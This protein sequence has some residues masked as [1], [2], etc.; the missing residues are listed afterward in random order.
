MKF[1]VLLPV[2]IF[3]LGCTSCNT[4]FKNNINNSIKREGYVVLSI[5][6]FKAADSA[7]SNFS[8]TFKPDSN[9]LIIKRKMYFLENRLIDIIINE[10]RSNGKFIRFDTIGYTLF[11]LSTQKF[12]TFKELALDASLIRKGSLDSPGG[13]FSNNPKFDVM[14]GIS[15]SGWYVSDTVINNDSIG[16]I[17]F[18]IENADSTE[19]EFTKMSKLWV[20]YSI[21]DFPLQI[22]YSLSKKLRNG[23]VYK[24]QQPFPD[25]KSF[26]ITS[27]TF[28]PAGLED[29]IK[30][31]FEAWKTITNN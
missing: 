3:I 10:N 14:S 8:Q 31:I 13:G 18:K 1:G 6:T 5:E 4:G 16:I 30:K 20:N 11:D 19:I 15:D 29:S 23:F 17:N 25:G 27:L 24:M 21:K 12:A 9:S 26:M 7:T 2:V 28:Q 22:S